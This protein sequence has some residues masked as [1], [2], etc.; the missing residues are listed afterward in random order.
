MRRIIS[1]I[2]LVLLNVCLATDDTI[3]ISIYPNSPGNTVNP[4][5]FGCSHWQWVETASRFQA[6]SRKKYLSERLGGL[7]DP[8]STVA[9]GRPDT[10]FTKL[11]KEAGITFIQFETS[12]SYDSMRAH[13]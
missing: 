1:V 7:W 6:D 2:I 5:L 4:F 12:D 3:Q 8:D 10:L 11:F 9:S 13:W